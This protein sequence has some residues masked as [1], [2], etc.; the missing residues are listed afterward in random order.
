MSDILQLQQ[1]GH[2]A[3][4]TLNR[5]KARNSLS[6]EMLARLTEAFEKIADDSEIKAVQLL[7]NGTIF[8]LSETDIKLLFILNMLLI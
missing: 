3:K 4:L 6:L 8:P 5:P 7:A 1:T 2:I